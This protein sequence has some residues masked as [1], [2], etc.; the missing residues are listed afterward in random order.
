MIQIVSSYS[1]EGLLLVSCKRTGTFLDF[2][3]Q[4]V[5]GLSLH[6]PLDANE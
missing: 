1:K 4:F 5:K 3:N 2:T 6:L